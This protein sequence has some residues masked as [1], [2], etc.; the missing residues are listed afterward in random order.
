MCGIISTIGFTKSEVNIFLDEISHRGTDYRGIEGFKLNE[1]SI[2]LGHNRLSINDLSSNGNQPMG[3]ENISLICN[4]EIW[5]Y[6]H[7]RK[8]YEQRGYKF[9]S[10][11]DNEIILYLYKEQELHRLDGMFSFVIYD[12]DK[13]TISRDWVG[14]TP[15]YL[16]QCDRGIIISSEHKIS[17]PKNSTIRFIPKNSLIEIEIDTLKITIK[18][19]FYFKFSKKE[20]IPKGIEE[21]G[22]ETYNLLKHAVEKRMI[23]DVK[24]GCCLSGG[25]DSSVITYLLHQRI[26]NLKTYTINFDESSEDL[27]MARLVSKHLNVD[28]VEVKVPKDENLLKERFL[29][30]IKV[31]EYPTSV[32]T[33]VCIL[34]SFL[35]EKM[36]EDGVKVG[37]SGEG[38]DESFGSYGMIRM[39]S[40][41]SDWSDIRKN[42]FEKQHYGN[43]LRGNNTFLYYGTIELRTPFFDTD[44]LNY[45]TNL[46]DEFLSDGNQ[47]KLPLLEGF[48][49]LLPTEVL[50]QQKRAFQKGVNFKDYIEDL[51]LN[52][53]EINF[54]GRKKFIN[55]VQDQFKKINGFSQRELRK[56]IV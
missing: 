25:I 12:D 4:G 56:S 21:V 13:L 15:L 39:F 10:N 47:W 18:N 20:Q 34:Q 5:N 19:N 2:F 55:V 30:S 28:L 50:N 8:E 45:I 7:L 44:Y 16:I 27:K 9:N 37:F 51:I 17:K 14:K 53:S 33:Q 22:K 43:L 31:V 36:K 48:R 52:D 35:V 6:P 3:F 23:S 38:A 40:K 11:S 1:K 46:K 24:I 41:K 42:L 32:Q 49:N 54:M 26:P 29:E